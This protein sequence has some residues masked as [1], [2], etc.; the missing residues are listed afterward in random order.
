MRLHSA[1]LLLCVFLPSPLLATPPSHCTASETVLWSCA[2]KR[3]VYSLCAS[4]VLT[5]TEG[6]LQYRAGP[7]GKPEFLF[8]ARTI[9]PA[10]QFTVATLAQAVR[11]AFS[12]DGFLYEVF[13][14]LKGEAS[15]VVSRQGRHVAD[16]P[17]LNST[18][19]LTD[20][21]T[22]SLLKAAGVG[23]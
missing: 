4:R 2:A 23:K 5:S 6:Y 3:K 19:S 17:C 7:F 1:A 13:D 15:I 10:G 16:V 14:P 22:L 18:H 12:N 9:P 11:V 20:T 21:A 8:P